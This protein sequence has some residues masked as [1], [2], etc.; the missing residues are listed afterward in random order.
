[1]IAQSVYMR[2]E[3]VASYAL[4]NDRVHVI[5]NG[6][7][8]TEFTPERR[9]E[10]RGAARRRWGIPEDARCLLF[11]G[12]NFRLK[13]LPA[14][15]RAVEAWTSADRPWLLVVG[16]GTGR[17]QRQ[18]ARQWV[19]SSGLRDRVVFG[20]PVESSLEAYAAAD[21]LVHPSWH[22]SFGFTVLE[23]MA[24][25]LP[26][27]T[28]PW[29]GAGELIESGRDGFVHDPR[30]T[31]GFNEAVEDSL[32]DA[33]AAWGRAAARTAQLYSETENFTAVERVMKLAAARSV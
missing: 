23:A 17:R 18:R 33:G 2:N 1:M 5:P 32:G 15:L 31:D 8:L 4:P 25:G 22:D 28:T 3:I 27:V 7:D 10:R 14:A 30:D 16:R 29:V 12:H 26:V 20:G 13:G 9:T 21:S 19:R 6:V 11:V 24:C